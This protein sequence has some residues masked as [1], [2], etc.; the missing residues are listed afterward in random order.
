[1]TSECVLPDRELE[2]W[3]L[4]VWTGTRTFLT[5]AKVSSP[6]FARRFTVLLASQTMYAS[7]ALVTSRLRP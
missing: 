1:M 6:S 2:N 4:Y 5:F 7:H 3:V